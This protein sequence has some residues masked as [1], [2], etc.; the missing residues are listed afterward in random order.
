MKKWIIRGVIAFAGLAILAAVF[1][2]SDG[3]SSS[4]GGNGNS[5][6]PIAL[7]R[8]GETITGRHFEAIVH[9]LEFSNAALDQFGDSPDPGQVFLILDVSVKNISERERNFRTGELFINHQSAELSFTGAETILSDGWLNP[10]ADSV[11]PL[12]TKRGKVAFQIPLELMD[13]QIQ[14][15]PPGISSRTRVLVQEGP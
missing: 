13:A 6:D 5:T 1:G 11:G 14:Y 9:S 12:V 4:G 2:T 15:A 3:P 8:I 10:L 7:P